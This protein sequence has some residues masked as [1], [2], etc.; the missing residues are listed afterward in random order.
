MYL[1]K[2]GEIPVSFHRPIPEG[3]EV[4]GVVV[5]RYSC[6]GWR[7]ILQLEIEK[8]D[9]KTNHGGYRH[10]GDRPKCV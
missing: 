2:V 8:P 1:S 10:Y 5:K 4:K 9:K 6:G 7:I 3:A